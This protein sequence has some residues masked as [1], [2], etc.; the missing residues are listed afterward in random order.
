MKAVPLTPEQ[1]R[2]IETLAQQAVGYSKDRGDTVNVVN[3]LFVPS[4]KTAL[5]ET[6]LWKDPE[7]VTGG[8]ELLRY[9]VLALVIFILWKKVGVPIKEK[10]FPEPEPVP[11]AEEGEEQLD[12]MGEHIPTFEEKVAQAKELA[13][14][15][16]KM[17]ANLVKEWV[18]GEPR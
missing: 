9:L 5:P 8:K 1:M 2:Q 4:E 11:E 16:P 3:S 14:A 6:P 12:E 7:V 17:V 15:D 10:L 18:N 13:K